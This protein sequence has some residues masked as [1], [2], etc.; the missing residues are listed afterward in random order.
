MLPVA[1]V[2][3]LLLVAHLSL[4]VVHFSLLVAHFVMLLIF[5]WHFHVDQEQTLWSPGL[6]L[7]LG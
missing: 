5:T 4:L 7:P 6:S 2:A 1:H 3:M